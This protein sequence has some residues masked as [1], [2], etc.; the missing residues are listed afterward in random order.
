[1]TAA[2]VERSVIRLSD[3]AKGN[4]NLL[5]TFNILIPA[6]LANLTYKR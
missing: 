6:L 1:M 5:S 4:K 2:K 3:L